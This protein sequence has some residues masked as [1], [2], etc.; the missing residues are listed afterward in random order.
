MHEN[1]IFM[2][3]NIDLNKFFD[4]LK[5][6]SDRGVVLLTA[7][8]LDKMLYKLFE[9]YLTLNED[10]KESILDNSLA[11]LN[12]FSNK[13]KMAHSLGLIDKKNYSN[14]EYIRKIRNKFSHDLYDISFENKQ[15]VDWCKNIDFPRIS[16]SS[17]NNYRYLFYD[18]SFF[19]SGLIQG[20]ISEKKNK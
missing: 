11:P 17:T 7:S 3:N 18:A 13:I 16:G 10:L 8:L 9:V 14:F 19:L 6:E 5:N 15:I 4:S 12:T 1:G 2:N 20:I